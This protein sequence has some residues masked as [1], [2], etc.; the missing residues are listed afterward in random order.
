MCADVMQ[1]N[2]TSPFR[3]V[4]GICNKTPLA[5]TETS[6]VLLILSETLALYK[7]FT[8]LFTYLKQTDVR[9]SYQYNAWLYSVIHL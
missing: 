7:S 4:R 6:S 2:V 1:C 9:R 3:T 5:E 8:Y